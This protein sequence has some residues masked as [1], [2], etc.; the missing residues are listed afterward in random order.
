LTVLGGDTTGPFVKGSGRLEL[1]RAISGHPL[2]ARVMANRI[3]IGHFGQG[4]V[5]SP[6]NF[7]QLGERPTHPELLEYL[8]ARL[9][10]SG[11]S[12]KTMHREIMLSAAYSMSSAISEKGNAADPD[13]RLLWRANL[14]QRLDAESLRDS[15]LFVAGKLS[16]ERGGPPVPL[17]G[18]NTR[19]TIYGYVGRTT[20]DPM[21]SLFDFPNPNNTSEQRSV[22]LG[23]MQRLYFM[24]NEFVADLARAFA[25]RVKSS[26][27]DDDGRIRAAYRLSFG[28]VPAAEEMGMAKDF[29]R[30]SGG[31][32]PQLTQALLTAAEFSSVN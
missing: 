6:S 16:P 28:R 12:L 1:A 23:P 29:L 7:G 9:I 32:W 24:N 25:E 31:A 26:G 21:L 5:R 10:E 30:A 13:N 18:S 20:L 17:D 22:T 4:I 14:T 11:W 19:R 27:P 2:A 8:S 15:M 3:W